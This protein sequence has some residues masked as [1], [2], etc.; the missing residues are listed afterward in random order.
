MNQTLYVKKNAVTFRNPLN[1][2]ISLKEGVP[3]QHAVGALWNWELA[4]PAEV[5][6]GVL[7][8]Y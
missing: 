5:N 2:L 1:K 4:D 3:K 6:T 8:G 7:L